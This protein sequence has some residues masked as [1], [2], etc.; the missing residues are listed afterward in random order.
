MSLETPDVGE[1]A[2]EMLEM[3][4]TLAKMTFEAF[5]DVYHGIG[6]YTDNALQGHNRLS[7]ISVEP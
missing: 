2:P 6:M 4:V 5:S 3:T 7:F 1:R